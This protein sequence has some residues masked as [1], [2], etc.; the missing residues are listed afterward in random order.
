MTPK[1]LPALG[2]R[3]HVALPELGVHRLRC[4][5]DTGAKTSALHA[6]YVEAFD[7]KGVKKV[8]FGLHPH[9]NSTT[10]EIH[11]EAPILDERKVTD[12]G[13]HTENRYVIRT[14]VVLG[15]HSWEI[16]ITLTNRDTMKYRM[17]LGRSAMVDNFL[18]D[19]SASY[20]AGKPSK[21]PAKGILLSHLHDE[22]EE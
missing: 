8:R 7:D 17:L 21:N 5:I 12:S 20:L 16:E 9:D 13:G 1:N 14:P 11:C 18:V 6:F 15:N 2:W 22:E 3:E 19:P 4:K 10:E